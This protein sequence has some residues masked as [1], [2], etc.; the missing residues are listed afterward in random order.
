MCRSPECDLL[1]CR[2]PEGL[3]MGLSRPQHQE[4]A[5]WAFLEPWIQSSDAETVLWARL[6]REASLSSASVISAL[7]G[8]L[9]T[10]SQD[11][12]LTDLTWG[13]L[14]AT[15]YCLLTG[16]DVGWS[17]KWDMGSGQMAQWLK[18]LL[19]VQKTKVWFS[20]TTPGSSQLPV[21]LVPGDLISSCGYCG[22]LN[23]LGAHNTLAGSHTWTQMKTSLLK[24]CRYSISLVSLV[25]S[26]ILKNHFLLV[27]K[28]NTDMCTCTKS[29]LWKCWS[30]RFGHKDSFSGP[31]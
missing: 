8:N 21:I 30:Q 2:H 29:C 19:L 4:S 15:C 18:Y 5:E 9:R 12:L 1:F 26:E 6:G 25:L 31:Q 24:M 16:C 20:G 22:R 14:M 27:S 28:K 3:L 11:T 13:H 17:L 7:G 10:V 23:A